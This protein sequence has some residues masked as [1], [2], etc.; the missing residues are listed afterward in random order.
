MD[1]NKKALEAVFD[2]AIYA[3]DNDYEYVNSET[4][5]RWTSAVKDLD[6]KKVIVLD[7]DLSEYLEKLLTAEIDG[8]GE[9]IAD[10]GI[11]HID[12]DVDKAE[13]ILEL[14]G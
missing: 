5:E 8:D 13:Q 11:R 7:A 4:L 10:V 9:E 2:A 6:A 12:S 14:L 3:I 1:D